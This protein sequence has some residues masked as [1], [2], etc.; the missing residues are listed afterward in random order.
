MK[1]WVALPVLLYPSLLLSQS[2]TE[3]SKNPRVCVA[4]VANAST[5]SAAIDSLT[6]RLAQDLKRNKVDV[7]VMD[8]STTMGRVLR[9]GRQNTDEADRKDC[10]YTLLTQIV[11]S[12]THPA[13]S[14]NSPRDGAIV[15]SVD[16]ADTMGGNSGPVYRENVQIA[17][18]LYRASHVDPVVDTS[19]LERAS[20]NVSDTFMAGMDRI[21]NRVRHELKVK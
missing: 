18:A 19:I 9:P 17:F 5:T 2:A 3:P 8:S 1:P 14:Q 12:R 10:D 6:E 21:A 4:V 13:G 15:P 16:A 11:E 20:A 7:A